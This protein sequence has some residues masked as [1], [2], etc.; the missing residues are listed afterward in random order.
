MC[1][2]KLSKLYP[3]KIGNYTMEHIWDIYIY[4]LCIS[5]LYPPKNSAYRG[6]AVD[7]LF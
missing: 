2:S 4:D 7:D 6:L 1:I 5:K 3:K